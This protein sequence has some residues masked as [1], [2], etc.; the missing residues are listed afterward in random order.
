ML[1][2][3]D[4][5]LFSGTITVVSK[6]RMNCKSSKI[7]LVKYIPILNIFFWVT[8]LISPCQDDLFLDGKTET[9]R[10]KDTIVLWES[11][12]SLESGMCS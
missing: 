9:E 7:N 12:F 8:T 1:I 5:I 6:L 10:Q 4:G 11:V 2:H 3:T